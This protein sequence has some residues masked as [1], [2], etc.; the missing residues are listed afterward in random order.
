MIERPQLRRQTGD[1]ITGLAPGVD[2]FLHVPRDLTDRAITEHAGAPG[3][4]VGEIANAAPVAARS[5]TLDVRRLS[6]SLGSEARAELREA[7]VEVAHL[8]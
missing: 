1:L 4:A 7:I 5:E 8:R 3:E 2:R 6:S